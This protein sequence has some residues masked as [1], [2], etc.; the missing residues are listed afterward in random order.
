MPVLINEIIVRGVVD[1]KPA[2]AEKSVTDCD[3]KGTSD[4]SEDTNLIERV[5]EV[6]REK[7]ER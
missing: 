3:M 7:N 5:L 1:S 2:L 4:G 6:I